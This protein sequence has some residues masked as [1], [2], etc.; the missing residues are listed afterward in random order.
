[1]SVVYDACV[2]GSG[3]AGG[4]MFDPSSSHLVFGTSP[5]NGPGHEQYETDIVDLN[6]GARTKFG[7]LFSSPT[8]PRRNRQ[9]FTTSPAFAFAGS[10]AMGSTITWRV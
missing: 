3:A 5:V 4:V 1:M 2:I 6:S 9:A 7:L 10:V 8:W